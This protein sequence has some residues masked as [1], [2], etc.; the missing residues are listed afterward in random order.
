MATTTKI[1]TTIFIVSLLI[2]SFNADPSKLILEFCDSVDNHAACLSALGADPKSAT[3]ESHHDLAQL[4]LNLAIANTTS[5]KTLIESTLTGKFDPN[6]TSE[7]IKG[8][9]WSINS[10]NNSLKGID[11]D[12]ESAAY[13]ATAALDGATECVAA[14]NGTKVE[15]PQEVLTRISYIQLFSGLANALIDHLY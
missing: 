7:C 2:N 8:F 11:D 9:S 6:I 15:I 1:L 12:A 13:D 10:F 4:A 14:F 5:S 3:I